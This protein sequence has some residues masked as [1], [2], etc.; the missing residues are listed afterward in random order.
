MTIIIL[1]QNKG[2]VFNGSED[3]CF[4]LLCEGVWSCKRAIL[5]SRNLDKIGK[6]T[7]SYIQSQVSA[8]AQSAQLWFDPK[9]EDTYP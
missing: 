4:S 9:H 8:K 2:F 3:I 7:M 1:G 6:R 5:L